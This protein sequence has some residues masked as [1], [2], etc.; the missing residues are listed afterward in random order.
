MIRVLRRLLFR[1]QTSSFHGTTLTISFTSFVSTYRRRFQ[2]PAEARGK[3]V[4]VDF[5]GAMT[6]STVWINGTLLGEYKGGFTPFTFELT[7]YLLP[8]AENVLCGAA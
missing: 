6:A 3:R 8:H 7:S 2:Y 1:I 5:E 4:F